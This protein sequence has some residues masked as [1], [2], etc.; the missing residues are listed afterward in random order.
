MLKREYYVSC[1]SLLAYNIRYKVSV[2]TNLNF[3]GIR[4][5]KLTNYYDKAISKDH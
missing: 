5:T 2:E 3:L 4:V 1:M